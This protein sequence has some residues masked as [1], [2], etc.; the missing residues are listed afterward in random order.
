MEAL[1]GII[2]TIYLMG[3]VGSLF[4]G[5][6]EL[7]FYRP[8]SSHI[9]KYDIEG[10]RRGRMLISGC[11]IWPLIATRGVLRRWRETGDFLADHDSRERA[12]ALRQARREVAAEREAERREF[13]RLLRGGGIK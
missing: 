5:F 3:V 2:V 10:M 1:I 7:S 12:E 13:D 4:G 11:L 6:M 9:N 8:G